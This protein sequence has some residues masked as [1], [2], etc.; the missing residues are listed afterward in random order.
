MIWRGE[1]MKKFIFLAAFCAL[2]NA[3][4][5]TPQC[6]RDDAKDV[7]VCS[8]KKLGN[9]MW[10]DGAEIFKGTLD[11]AKQYCKDLN[12]AGFSD[13]KLPSRT[14]LISITAGRY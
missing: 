9:L 5:I 2:L 7:V 12:F 8:D 6:Q 13:W 4:E 3:A 14:E 10:Q 11:E 1:N